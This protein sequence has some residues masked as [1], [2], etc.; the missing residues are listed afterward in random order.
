MHVAPLPHRHQRREGSPEACALRRAAV[1]RHR[2]AAL[3]ALRP[4]RRRAVRDRARRGDLGRA[5]VDRRVPPVELPPGRHREA[6]RVADR[7]RPDAGLPVRHGATSRPRRPRGARRAR[8]RRVAEDLGRQGHAHLRAHRA[9]V[10]L[11]R[12]PSSGAG[13]RPRGRAACARRRHHDVVAQGPRSDRAVR[14]LQPERPRPHHGVRVLGAW[15][16]RRRACRRRSRW[17]EID[18]VEPADFTIAT[19]PRAVRRA[20]RPARRHRRRGLRDRP[21]AGVGRPRRARGCR[22][23]W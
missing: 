22:R 9:V 7:S 1:A 6:R 2:A 5:D 16:A 3:P 15:R 20:R 4:A 10:R 23:R 18:D 8:R 17:D 19:V 11:H 12:R 13:V 14:R 21:A